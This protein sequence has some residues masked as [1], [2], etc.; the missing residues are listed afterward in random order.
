MKLFK[1]TVN[2]LVWSVLILYLTLIVTLNI[3]GIQEWLGGKVAYALAGKL[4][5]RVE[6]RSI[7]VGPLNRMV[8]DDICI[9]DRQHKK[10]VAAGRLSARIELSALAA[11]R[12]SISSA[13]LFGA[14]INLYQTTPDSLHNFQ[15]AID[16]L[17][18]EDTTQGAPLNLRV[19]SLIIRKGRVRY[20]RHFHTQTPG[21][22]NTSHIDAS[23]ISAHI[24]LKAL[25]ED[26]INVNIK[27]ISLRE[28]CGLNVEKL[29]MKLVAG[30]R[31]ARLS[32]LYIKLHNSHIEVPEISAEYKSDSTGIIP[33]S[34]RY[35]GRIAKSD[36]E[37][38]DIA[39]LAKPLNKQCRNKI[40]LS[41]QFNGTGTN[42]R[43]T[44]LSGTL[45]GNEM[46]LDATAWVRGRGAAPEWYADI[47][48]LHLAPTAPATIAACLKPG[49]VKLPGWTGR[50][51]AVNASGR[52][53]GTAK[54]KIAVTAGIR[55]DAGDVS[56]KMNLDKNR[57][58]TAMVETGAEGVNLAQL[59]DNRKLGRINVSATAGGHI[60]TG[61]DKAQR[62]TEISVKAG[63][64]RLDYNGYRFSGITA[65]GVLGKKR[66]SGKLDIADPNARVVAEGH[67]TKKDLRTNI[68]LNADISNFSPRETALSGK[69][70]DARFAAGISADFA[71]TDINDAVGR[72]E[73]NN[74]SMTSAEKNY[75]LRQL[76]VIS[77]VNADGEHFM[78]LHSD[79]GKAEINGHLD[80][81][82]LQESLAAQIGAH[83]PELPGLSGM[84]AGRHPSNRFTLSATITKSD[85]AENLLGYPVRLTAPATIEMALDDKRPSMSANIA[86]PEF[87]ISGKPYR[88]GKINITSP[89]DSLRCN[90]RLTKI[91]ANNEPMELKLNAD[92]TR[93]NLVSTA[94]INLM[95]DKPL[96]GRLNTITYF[97]SENDGTPQA[98]INILP[99]QIN[100]TG[101]KWDV[102]RSKISVKK[103]DIR[104]NAFAITHNNQHIFINGAVTPLP[105]DLL[106][107]DL[108]GVDVG[109][110]LNLVNFHSVEFGGRASGRA[111]INGAL[112]QIAAN[113]KIMVND[114]TF[115]NG[116]MGVLDADV[117]WNAEKKQIDIN[118]FADNGPQQMTYIN[119]YVSPAHNRIDL[120]IK[121]AGTNIEFLESFTGSFMSNVKGS[122]KGKV[123]V[124]GPLN[125][126]NLVGQLAV[127]GEA[128]IIPLGCKYFLR[129]DTVKFIPNEIIL[130]NMPV[131]DTYGN[132]GIVS[133]QLHHRNLSRLTYD[134]NV[135]ATNLMA[136]NFPDFGESNICGVV[137]ATGNVD[138]IGR[139]G[140]LTINVDAT[141]QP[142]STFGYNVATPDAIADNEFIVWRDKTTASSTGIT[143]EE[144]RKEGNSGN[145][146]SHNSLQPENSSDTR[147][148]FLVNC[149]P[150]ATIR[151]RMDS[152]GE[153]YITLNGNGVIRATYYNKGPFT[154]FGTYVVDHGTYGITIQDILKKNFTFNEGGTI[155]FGGDP[156][157]ASLNLQAVHTVNGVSL[158]DLNIG[159]SFTSSTTKVN[160]LMNISGQPLKPQISFDIDI[161]TVSTDEKQMI[162]SLINS[163]EEMNQQVV[164]LLGIGRFYPQGNNNATAQDETQQSQTSLAMQS[165]L[166]GTISGQIN[167]VLNTV[168]KSNTWNFGANIS[169]GNE[170][171]NN[172]EY[173]GLLSGRLLNNRLLI[174][175]QFGYRD[176]A[177]TASPSFI[178]DFDI[179]YLLN[180][181]GNLALKIYNQTNDRYFTNSSLNTQGIGIIMKKDFNG[182]G[183][184]FRTRKKKKNKE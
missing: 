97:K 52:A 162:R 103:D 72:L 157:N 45:N 153:D 2:I 112:G 90:I 28:H 98:E 64:G 110:I 171:W 43:V 166:S 80:Y 131:Y 106:T 147:I 184:L 17:A 142:N 84:H 121:A 41:L 154:M 67:I 173:E 26:S 57:M 152:K 168:I 60:A 92:A 183:D 77:G 49:T 1:H 179:R 108:Q 33:A 169:T 174:N 69:W 177:K 95:G 12:I 66:I 34:L 115:E 39:P 74:M 120:G 4:G 128:D 109:Y 94:E 47:A 81:S 10:M 22:M 65:E 138:I 54:D 160:C 58:A 73:I 150:D 86:L 117:S 15:F 56:V 9:Y 71:V 93:G 7:A 30:K 99:S 123:S 119:G 85:W 75:S 19:N 18:S 181:A 114:F 46:Q 76:S 139:K 164:Y 83:L 88:G 96:N 136:Y 50:I 135:K 51:G 172:A 156:F 101:T 59:L 180:P 130:C 133:G 16:A 104:I 27:K 79:F 149:N 11:G 178:G 82:K 132:K 78:T 48:N 140:E 55:T 62:P 23:D 182:L 126:I 6:I 158:A 35:K 70:K 25:R 148:N 38:A 89:N 13:Q 21:V 3:P 31:N 36:I 44:S 87:S 146:K 159:N 24:V 107:V 116:R 5:T 176:N 129:N 53:G 14:D 8:A 167:N 143:A 151:L 91:M 102:H 113:G 124:V 105:T 145:T 118:A 37:I 144:S 40:A 20:N 29:A 42:F 125:E 111:Y 165:L 155:V 127:N 175:G 61:N 163:E 68:K 100:L 134:L 32:D 161:P 141:P 170:G 63:I 122:A 137:F